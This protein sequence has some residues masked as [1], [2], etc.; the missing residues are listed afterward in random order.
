RYR[1]VRDRGGTRVASRSPLRRDRRSHV[2]PHRATRLRDAAAGLAGPR[3]RLAPDL[4]ALDGQLLRLE[5]PADDGG[6]WS[7]GYPQSVDQHRHPGPP[8]YLSQAARH[9]ARAGDAE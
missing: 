4:D 7:V 8:R 2:A 3:Q 9:D 1:A 5:A 6:G